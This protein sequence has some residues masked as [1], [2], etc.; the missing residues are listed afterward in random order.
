M[1][2]EELPHT[3]D[4]A[5]HVWAR[6]LPGLYADAARGMCALLAAEPAPGEMQSRRVEVHGADAESLLVAYL[7]ELLYLTETKHLAFAEFQVLSAEPPTLRA[8]ARGQPLARL[9]RWI[10]AVTFHTLK[11]QS[12]AEGYD[13][14]IVLDV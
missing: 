7:Q 4:L 6:D 8:E 10:K 12:T 11:I 5:L 3:A 9:G 2:C 13:V 14:T 1:P